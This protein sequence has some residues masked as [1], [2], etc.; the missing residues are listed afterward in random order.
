MSGGRIADCEV[1]LSE[2]SAKWGNPVATVKLKN[3][4]TAQNIHFKQP[5][6]GRYL[7]VIIKSTHGKNDPSAAIA[8]L[9]IIE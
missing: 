2:D 1:Y 9:G 4:P 8:E 7:K 5:S 3:E 6:T